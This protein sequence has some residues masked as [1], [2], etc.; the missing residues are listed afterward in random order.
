MFQFLARQRSPSPVSRTDIPV[1]K[2]PTTAGFFR[3]FVS[4]FDIPGHFYVQLVTKEGQRLDD[5]NAKMTE[6]YGNLQMSQGDA[7]PNKVVLGEIYCAPF[8]LDDLWYRGNVIEVKEEEK[9]AVLFYIDY[10]D[11]GLVQFDDLR[12][13]K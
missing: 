1:S 9:A 3:V 13:P 5:L 2:L 8:D 12:K 10:G 6:Y 4:A 7:P 11:V